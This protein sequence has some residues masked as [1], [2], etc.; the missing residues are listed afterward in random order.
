LMYGFMRPE[1]PVTSLQGSDRAFYE[2]EFD[3]FERVTG[4][5]GLMKPYINKEKWEKKKKIDEELGKIAVD[6]GVYLPSNPEC[7]VIDI[8]YTS[9]RPLQSQAKVNKTQNR[10]ELR[11][12]F[13]V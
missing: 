1:I 6:S 3:F 10:L 13:F 9:G 8:D 2:R 12:Q 11:F 4:I 7:S 5:S